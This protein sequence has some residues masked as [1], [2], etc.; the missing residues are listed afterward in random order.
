MNKKDRKLFSPFDVIIILFVII[1]SAFAIISQ[2]N[3]ERDNLECVIKVSGEVTHTISL[4]DVSGSE[5]ISVDAALP[6]TVIVSS[7]GVYVESASCPDKLCEHTGKITRSG[8][9]IVCLPAKVSVSLN[10]DLNSVDTVVG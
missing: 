5:K 8:Q 10:G 2:F 7:D 3:N 9:S 6:V 1:A 4:D